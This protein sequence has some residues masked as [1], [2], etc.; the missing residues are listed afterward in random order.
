MK[1]LAP[2]LLLLCIG[3]TRIETTGNVNYAGVGS[4]VV[5]AD[6]ST[7]ATLTVNANHAP[8]ASWLSAVW[9]AISGMFGG[10]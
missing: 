10:K 7:S 8:G 1:K 5:I 9:A 6:A 4:T 3:C 2:I